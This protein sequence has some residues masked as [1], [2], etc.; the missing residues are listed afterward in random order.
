MIEIKPK[1][2]LLGRGPVCYRN[3]G[4]IMFR[5]FI[6]EHYINY[7]LTTPRGMKKYIVKTLIDK[8]HGMG[9]RFLV[10][11]ENEHSWRLAHPHL[12]QAK[13]GHALRDARA[14]K[15]DRLAVNKLKVP[16]CAKETPLKVASAMNKDCIP[17]VENQQ[18]VRGKNNKTKFYKSLIDKREVKPSTEVF[19]G[20]NKKEESPNT[21]KPNGSKRPTQVFETTND[22]CH[23]RSR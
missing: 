5:K 2:I 20:K 12:I 19:V 10:R 9:S 6:T 21:M 3:P 17:N 4:N 13:V 23:A 7:M 11:S 16:A 1:D 14:M 18:S 8:I 22:C 15:I